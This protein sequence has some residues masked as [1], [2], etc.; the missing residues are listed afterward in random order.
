MTAVPDTAW[1]RLTRLIPR[2]ARTVVELGREEPAAAEMFRG[3]NP[4]AR[5]AAAPL[6]APLPQAEADGWDC[7]AL[8][9]SF[10]RTERPIETLQAARRLLKPHA[11]LLAVM[12]RMRGNMAERLPAMLAAADLQLDMAFPVDDHG[13]RFLV[14]AVPRGMPLRRLLIQHMVL[15]PAGGVNDKRI[16]EPADFLA[17]IPGV[18]IAIH[19]DSAPPQ[20]S[21][22]DRILV[23]Q[24][25]LLSRADAQHLR[26]TAERGYVV[27]AEFDDHP[28][29]WP[30]VAENDHATFRAAHGVQTSTPLLAGELA[31][32]NDEIAVFPN[33][34]ATLPPERALPAD[35]RVTIFFGAFNREEEWAPVMPALQRIVESCRDRLRFGVIHDR[36]FYDALPT[37]SKTFFSTCPYERYLGMLARCD[38]ALLPLSDTLFNRCK[39][40]LKFIECAANQVVALAS[41]V[42]YA[43]SLA[44]G[45]TGMLFR[46]PEEFEHKLRFLIDN[47]AERAAIA[48]RARTWAAENRLMVQ[49]YRKRHDWYLSMVARK[50]TL[51]A[52]LS[53]QLDRL[54]EDIRG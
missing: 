54:K 9:E 43:D 20:S 46:S 31:P 21:P 49:H 35:G 18:Q 39:S 25:R 53:R 34:M 15:K 23:V 3:W 5:F 19:Q 37:E 13:K 52:A 30:I 48:G 2:D 32:Y 14:R 1:L 26:S 29:R 17:T 28:S 50:P 6:G 40:D 33:Q 36:A 44:D 47:G 45:R 4:T 41:P 51:D 8:D 7:V 16:L 10:A 11:P 12:P 27:V 22:H 24:R 38:I 42:V